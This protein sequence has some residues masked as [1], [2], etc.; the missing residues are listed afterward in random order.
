M[1]TRTK[2]GIPDLLKDADNTKY[3]EHDGEKA[4]VLADYFGSV[5]TKEPDGELPTIEVKSVPELA[6]MRITE[7]LVKKQL[8]KIKMTRWITHK[9]AT[10]AK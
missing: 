6:S 3:T 2:S 5:F 9:S 10:R 8:G 4:E 1:K 7:N